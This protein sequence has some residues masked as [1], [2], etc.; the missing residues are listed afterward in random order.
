L[1]TKESTYQKVNVLEAGGVVLWVCLLI[2]EHAFV[3][4]LEEVFPLVRLELNLP[5]R[6]LPFH[7]RGESVC[8][9]LGE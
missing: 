3:I 5:L 4:D 9:E 7:R 2:V 1:L 8:V 6:S